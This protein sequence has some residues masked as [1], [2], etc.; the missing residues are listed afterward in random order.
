M[1]MGTAATTSAAPPTNNVTNNT[2][3]PTALLAVADGRL[4]AV[5]QERGAEALGMLPP[6]RERGQ[7][8]VTTA[9][10]IVG[11]DRRLN[12]CQFP[13]SGFQPMFRHLFRQSCRCKFGFRQLE[14]FER[15]S[16]L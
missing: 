11:S 15:L 10:R 6:R 2:P 3:S 16:Y 7:R 13:T 5:W 14:L 9:F 1:T 4:Q 12:A 8:I